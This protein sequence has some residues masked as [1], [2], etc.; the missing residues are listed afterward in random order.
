MTAPIIVSPKN[1]SVEALMYDGTAQSAWDIMA[2]LRSN[3]Y[4]QLRSLSMS[5]LENAGMP[6]EFYFYLDGVAHNIAPGDWLI[7][8]G[9]MFSSCRAA[10]FGDRFEVVL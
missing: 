7:K 3:P 8:D 10:E 5:Y 4:A 2:V 1:E 6:P 9:D